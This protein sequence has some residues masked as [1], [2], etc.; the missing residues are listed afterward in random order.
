MK[1]Q[2]GDQKIVAAGCAVVGSGRCPLR[3]GGQPGHQLRQRRTFDPAGAGACR[4]SR[5]PTRR[6][7]G[8]LRTTIV[9]AT[10]ARPASTPMA[11][12]TPASALTAGPVSTPVQVTARHA[13]GIGLQ[14]TGQIVVGGVHDSRRRLTRS[15]VMGGFKANGAVNSGKGGFG[16]IVHGKATGYTLTTFGGQCA[17]F[18]SIAVQPDNKMVAVG[19]FGL[20]SSTST[21]KCS[22]RGTPPTASWTRRSMAAGTPSSPCRGSAIQVGLATRPPRRS[23]IRRED[24]RPQYLPSR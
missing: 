9:L 16:Q 7:G 17:E 8:C 20:D 11:R 19:D 3:L 2:P 1:I 5:A 18:T 14:S 22:W 15:A 6:Q 13:T 4:W 21:T 10:S 24:R 12:S 23:A